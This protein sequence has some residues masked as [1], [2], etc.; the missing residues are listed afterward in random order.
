MLPAH[1]CLETA[2]R[3]CGDVDERLVEQPEFAVGQRFAQIKV[4]GAPRLHAGVHVR[5]EELVAAAPVGFGTVQRH[6][7]ILDDVVDVFAVVG[8]DRDADTG[9]DND[10][11]SVEFVWLADCLDHP[12]GQGG[13]VAQLTD[14]LHDGELVAAEPGD[15]IGL[16][17]L[18]IQSLGDL[19]QQGV[20]DR[21]TKGV[22]HLLEVIEV[23]VKHRAPLAPKA[24]SQCFGQPVMEQHPVRQAGQR[25][26]AGHVR[27]FG[28]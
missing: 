11:T 15:R 26:V 16:A 7:S 2:N 5:F 23:E 28:F 14:E 20:A 9:A 24:A 27:D 21:V 10:T 4:E 13:A 17:H 12:D 3:A 19:P 8:D 1:E 6:I 25:V 18:L 22:V